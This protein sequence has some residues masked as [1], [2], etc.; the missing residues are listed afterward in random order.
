MKKLY[1]L[2][3][4]LTLLISCNKIREIKDKKRFEI[5]MNQ[6]AL[7]IDKITS[8]YNILYHWDSLDYSNS[9]DYMQVTNTKF[10]IIDNFSVGDI[11]WNK[12]DSSY[13]ITV[14]LGYYPSFYFDLF[15]SDSLL[16]VIKEKYSREFSIGDKWEYIEEIVDDEAQN[17]DLILIVR[18]S[19]IRKLRFK[20]DSETEGE[21]EDISSSILIEESD[22]FIGK[23]TLY[24]VL[25][26]I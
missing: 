19:D 17:K 25:S 9:I 13:H 21:G 26:I 10:Q 4:C 15:C 24:S 18:I 14:S 2:I 8:D 3:P 20:I 22:D 23:G 5:L 11:Y 12:K 6:K 1:I 7:I 16:Q